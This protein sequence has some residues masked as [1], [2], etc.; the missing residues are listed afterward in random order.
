MWK[1]SPTI[2]RSFAKQLVGEYVNPTYVEGDVNGDEIF[3]VGET[4]YFQAKELATRTGVNTNT[5]KVTASDDA[6]TMVM[7]D[8]PANYIINFWLGHSRTLKLFS[9]LMNKQKNS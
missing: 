3:N 5:I 2:L 6:G 1:E 7:D 8:D 4:W 9:D